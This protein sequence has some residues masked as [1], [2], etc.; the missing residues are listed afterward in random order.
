MS[1]LRG[2]PMTTMNNA[3]VC[4]VLKGVV[5]S[6]N[7]FLIFPYLQLSFGLFQYKSLYC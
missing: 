7:D 3:F 4:C 2:F 1:P 6:K 5:E